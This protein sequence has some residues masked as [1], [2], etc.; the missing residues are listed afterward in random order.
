MTEH[1]FVCRLDV[2]PVFS[3]TQVEAVLEKL[4]IFSNPLQGQR[5]PF[6]KDGPHFGKQGPFLY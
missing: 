5:V 4:F 3:L 6:G 1:F 2:A